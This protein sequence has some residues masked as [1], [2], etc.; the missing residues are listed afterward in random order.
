MWANFPPDRPVADSERTPISTASPDRPRPPPPEALLKPLAR[1]LRPLVRLLIQSGVTFPVLADL[2]RGIYVDVARRE[3]LTDPKAQ[4]DSRVSLLTGIHRKEIRRQRAPELAEAEPAI[5]TLASEIIGRWLGS[6]TYTDP[7]RQPLQLSRTGPD[8]SFEGLVASVTRDVRPRAVLD[9]LVDQ[10]VV[11]I[12]ETGRVRLNTEAF[13][14]R[15]GR[16]AQLFYFARNLHD[17]IAAAAANII[18][19]GTPPF[20][21]RSVHYD[22]LDADAAARLEAA[23]REAAQQLLLDINRLALELA[24]P[25]QEQGDVVD[26]APAPTRRVNLGLYLYAEDEPPATEE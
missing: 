17:H 4:T 24:A 11:T 14:P 21:D 12:G 10:G 5:V 3:L 7:G 22:G 8:P 6:P 16:E 20:L 23:A 26:S 2:M 1:L 13:I 15:E 19:A 18:A 25:R 9:E